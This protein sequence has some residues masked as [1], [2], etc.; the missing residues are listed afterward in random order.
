VSEI[1]GELLAAATAAGGDRIADQFYRELAA[2]ADGYGKAAEYVSRGLF[3]PAVL[4][5]VAGP[6]AAGGGARAGAGMR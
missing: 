3:D 6:G 1:R 2:S 4:A 5:V